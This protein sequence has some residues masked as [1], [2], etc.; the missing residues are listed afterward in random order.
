MMTVSGISSGSNTLSEYT[1]QGAQSKIQQ[2][3]QEFQ[4]LGQDLASGNLTAAQ[5]NFA[6]LQQANPQISS[7]PSAQSNN[8]IAQEFSQLSQDLQAGNVSA[9]QQDYTKIQQDFQ[10]QAGQM[11]AHHKHQGGASK[12]KQL[13]DQAGQALLSSKLSAAKQAYSVV[14]QI[15]RNP[16][17][18]TSP[19]SSASVSLNA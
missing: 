4:Q 9:A 2:F 12:I 15:F 8:P 13:L 10:N 18:L 7:T 3:R 5:A 11:H 19:S 14:Q 6:L 1:A 16:S 17:G